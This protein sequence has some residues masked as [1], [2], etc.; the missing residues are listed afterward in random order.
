MIENGEFN[1][2]HAAS[3]VAYKL[4]SKDII[5]PEKMYT[6]VFPRYGNLVS[7][8]IPAGLDLALKEGLLARGDRVVFLPASAGMVFSVVQFNY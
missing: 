8:S 3:S 7:A 1:F 2:P 4:A 5:S 6:R